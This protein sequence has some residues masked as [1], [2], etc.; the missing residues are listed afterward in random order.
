LTVLLD[1]VKQWLQGVECPNCGW[2]G[3]AFKRRNR[4]GKPAP[5]LLCRSC[6]SSSRHR[7]ARVALAPVFGQRIASTLHFAPER[8]IE[9]WLRALSSEYL[10]VDLA[11]PRAMQR[12]DITRLPLEDDR[13]SMVWC[14][15]VLEHIDDDRRAMAELFRVV[16][17]GGMAAIM[18][19][20][21]GDATREDSAIT[22]PAERLRHF[23]QQD[24]VRTYGLDIERRL[25]AA[26]FRVEVLRVGDLPEQARARHA[27]DYPS[28]REIFVCRKPA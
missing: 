27:L 7:F 17:P 10:S 9:P 16:R 13:F 19:P 21:Y 3:R 14:S 22:T 26:G 20:I 4:P 28:T 24:H 12:M 11:S 23:G 15:H 18:V 1:R 8:S 2:S 6:G 25:G 5:S